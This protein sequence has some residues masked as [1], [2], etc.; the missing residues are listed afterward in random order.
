MGLHRTG[1][2]FAVIDPLRLQRLSVGLS[3]VG[4]DLS[5]IPLGLADSGAVPVGHTVSGEALKPPSPVHLTAGFNGAGDL[6]CS[7]CRRSRLG[8]A[9][10]DNVD[11]PLE[12]SSEHY[13]VQLKGSFSSIE[14]ETNVA[15]ATFAAADLALLGSDLTLNVTQIGDFAVSSPTSIQILS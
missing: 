8:W 6:N 2:I 11:A 12:C 4:S 5:V 15:N 3:A 7:W 13:R 1:E 10:I 9:W 14:L